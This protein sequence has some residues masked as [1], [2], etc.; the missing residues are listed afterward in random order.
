MIK[1]SLDQKLIE[2]LTLVGLEE[3]KRF[4]RPALALRGS[5]AIEDDEELGLKSLT[6]KLQEQRGSLGS[7]GPLYPLLEWVKDSKS[8]DIKLKYEL[9]SISETINSPFNPFTLEKVERLIL[10]KDYFDCLS[11]HHLSNES[12]IVIV[13]N[14]HRGQYVKRGYGDK[15]CFMGL[16]DLMSKKPKASNIATYVVRSFIN[17]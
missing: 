3:P 2:E 14:E 13:G 17:K 9:W 4:Y 6:P 5:Y 15:D 11:L 16:I 7:I 8:G 1:T 10:S 12:G